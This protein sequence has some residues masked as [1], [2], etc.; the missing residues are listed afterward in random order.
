M[1]FN[2]IARPCAQPKHIEVQFWK[3]SMLEKAVQ[4]ISIQI[5]Y[6]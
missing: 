6:V 5:K 1:I 3:V 2:L 4:Y